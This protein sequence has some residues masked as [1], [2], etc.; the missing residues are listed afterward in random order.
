[1]QAAPWVQPAPSAPPP[2]PLQNM[3]SSPPN[4]FGPSPA[5]HD[6]IVA[7]IEKLADLHKKCILTDSEYESKKAEL[8]SRL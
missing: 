5:Q 2:P 6:E 7:L 3:A 1:M 8:L 4:Q